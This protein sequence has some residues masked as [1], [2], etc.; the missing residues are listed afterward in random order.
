[1][2]VTLARYFARMRI[3]IL[4]CSWRE[5]RDQ[6]QSFGL[7]FFWD[8]RYW[9]S[10][11]AGGN[12]PGGRVA[13]V[14]EYVWLGAQTLRRRGIQELAEVASGGRRDGS[15][16]VSWSKKREW[17]SNVGKFE[18]VG[19]GR[20]EN[21]NPV[22]CISFIKKEAGSSDQGEWGRVIQNPPSSS[23]CEV[24]PPEQ[25]RDLSQEPGWKCQACFNALEPCRPSGSS[26]TEK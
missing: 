16:T 8:G 5:I 12:V 1:M 23:K 26:A 10:V 22:A 4:G 13:D 6:G 21:T 19:G 2:D 24:H 17:G 18:G 15:S 7:I 25:D 9:G 20:W 3:R 14:C 11:F